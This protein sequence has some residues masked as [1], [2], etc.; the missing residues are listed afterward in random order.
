MLRKPTL[1]VFIISSASIIAGLFALTA[2]EPSQPSAPQPEPTISQADHGEV[3]SKDEANGSRPYQTSIKQPSPA[4]SSTSRQVAS[5]APAT[6]TSVHIANGYMTI[7]DKEYPIRDYEPLMTPNDPAA[8]QAWV[9]SSKLNQAWDVAS[10]SNPTLLAVIDTGVALAHQEFTNRWFS[11]SG[12]QGATGQ[13]GISAL[14]C[15]ARGL[16]VSASCNLVDDDA[17]GIVDEETGPASRENPSRLNCT[18][19]AKPL[20]KSCNRV[21]DDLNDYTDDVTGWDFADMDNSVQAGELNPTGSGTTHGTR[22]AGLAAATGNNGVGIAGVDWQTK[23]LPIQALSDDAQGDTYGVGRA[24]LYAAS[25]RADVINLSLGSVLPDEY[26]REAIRVATQKGSLVVAA[27]GNDGCNC[28]V[29]PANYP[30][31]LTVG[32]LDGTNPAS[33]SS[34]GN[35]LDIMAPGTGIIS[36]S[37]S[38]GNPTTAYTSGNAGTSF[39]API[40]SGLM[41]RLLSQ[42][43]TATPL[44]LIAALTENS[45]RTGLDSTV[46]R[47]NNLGYGKLDAQTATNRMHTARSETQFY[48]FSN[49]SLGAA[50]NPVSPLEISQDYQAIYCGTDKPGTTPIYELTKAGSQVF[51]ISPTEAWT[52][53]GDGYSTTPFFNACLSQPHDSISI[54]R[55]INLNKEFRNI[56]DYLKP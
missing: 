2:H 54:L 46:S 15:T 27:A 26:V 32:A 13:E 4:K 5:L 53:Q 16:P 7:N 48:R 38:A 18:D 8:S 12:E 56:N 25:M 34:Y 11:N 17:D 23:I 3:S 39:S 44:Q 50:L 52:A 6:Q 42:Q 55:D 41:T 19:Q 24:I 33:F 30:E 28:M 37:W 47:S 43:P 45:D 35:N 51:T 10:G 20:D 29:Y 21:D 31:V 1:A 22:V 14:N 49:V 40:I 36:S 9:A